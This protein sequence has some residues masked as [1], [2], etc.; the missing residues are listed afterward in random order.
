MVAL[1]PVVG[2]LVSVV[3]RVGQHLRD[4]MLESPLVVKGGRMRAPG[5]PH[6]GG[7]GV[8]VDEDVVRWYEAVDA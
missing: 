7:L 8:A 3:E 4:D 1:D 6:S 2:A 5:G